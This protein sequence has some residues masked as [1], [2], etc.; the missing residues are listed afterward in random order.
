MLLIPCYYYTRIG[1]AHVF[2]TI[3]HDKHWKSADWENKTGA[4]GISNLK[5]DQSIVIRMAFLL[6]LYKRMMKTSIY[7]IYSDK[8]QY[9]QWYIS[10]LTHGDTTGQV[11]EFTWQRDLH[12]NEIHLTYLSINW[13]LCCTDRFK[14]EHID[15]LV[16]ERR[17]STINALDLRL[18]CTK[19]STWCRLFASTPHGCV[20]GHVRQLVQSRPRCKLSTRQQTAHVTLQRALASYRESVM[21]E[22]ASKLCMAPKVLQYSFSHRI[23]NIL[24]ILFVLRVYI[25]WCCNKLQTGTKMIVDDG[26][27]MIEIDGDVTRYEGAREDMWHILK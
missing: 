5:L 8:M 21:L 19:P 16:Q 12:I 15:R 3:I 18:S 23:R 26:D 25:T 2:C 14:G 11:T 24:S 7:R 22:E 27:G 20:W 4:Q 6:Q 10:T 13:I 1:A 17:N 9:K